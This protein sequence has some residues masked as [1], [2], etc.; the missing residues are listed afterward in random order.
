MKR[1]LRKLFFANMDSPKPNATTIVL[2]TLIETLNDVID[3]VDS[4]QERVEDACARIID[5]ERTKQED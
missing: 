3:K 4:L 1:F 2:A 5:L